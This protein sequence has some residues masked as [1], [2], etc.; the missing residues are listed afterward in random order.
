MDDARLSGK[1]KGLAWTGTEAVERDE[2]TCSCS[3]VMA[4]SCIGQS[5]IAF[6]AQIAPSKEP[7][8]A[9][10]AA[11]NLAY[12]NSMSA[13]PQTSSSGSR[14]LDMTAQRSSVGGQ[15]GRLDA[16]DAASRRQDRRRC[17]RRRSV[18][19]QRQA[20]NRRRSI[21]YRH[22]DARRAC[23]SPVNRCACISRDAPGSGDSAES[24]CRQASRP[25]SRQLE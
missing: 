20:I 21:V 19:M 12:R 18:T 5:S 24:E 25:A 6:V 14:G 2:E 3:S 11:D 7:N 16:A 8:G 22:G 23:G 10:S 1:V 15:S 9:Y 17:R 4:Q 13:L